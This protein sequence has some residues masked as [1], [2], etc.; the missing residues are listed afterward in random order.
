MALEKWYDALPQLLKLDSLQPNDPEINYKLGLAHFHTFSKSKS[1]QN[2]LA[3]SH[4]N[5]D[6]ADLDYYLGRAYQYNHKFTEAM[7]YYQKYDAKLDLK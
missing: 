5:Y 7:A 2:F 3:A 6:A 1:L 4:G